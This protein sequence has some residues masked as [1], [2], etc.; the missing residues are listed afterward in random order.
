GWRDMVLIDKGPTPN[1]G[2]STGH[3]SNFIF[4][5][6]YS[7]MMAELTRDSAEQYKALGVHIESGGI[8]VARTQARLDEQARRASAARSCGIPAERLSP[9]GVAERVPYLD[10]SVIK[11][12]LY[13]PTVGVVD[14]LRAGTLMREQA[15]ELG[16]LSVRAGTEV[17]G[18]D[19]ARGRVR[20]VQT[21]EGEIETEL[22]VICCGV[23]SPRLARMAGARIPLTPIVHQM[24]SVGPVPLF[25][26]TTGEIAYPVVRDVDTG[27][28]ERQH[29]ADL[30]IGSYAHRPITVEPDDIPSIEHSVLSPTELPFTKEDFDPQLQDALELMPELLGD[31][32]IG[33]RY[34][35]NGLI[36]MTPDGHPVLGE[37]PEVRGLWTA[38]ASWIKEGPGIGRAVAERMSGSAPEIDVR[39]ADVSRFYEHQ[40]TRRVVRGRARESFNKM[41]G[42]VHPA[43]QWQDGRP[44]RTSPFYEQTRALGAVFHETAGFERP[45]WYASNERLLDRYGDK[46]MPRSAE[47]D[48]RWWSPVINA[49]HLAM[50][51]GCAVVDLGAFAVLDIAGPRATAALQHLTVVDLDV[52]V[53]RVVYTSLLDERGG[54]VSD[55]TAMRL[56]ADRWW[57]VTGASSGMA[58]KKWILD[59]LPDDGS[60]HLVDMTQAIATLGVWGPNARRLLQQIC[61]DDL[62]PA[63]FPFGTCRHIEIGGTIVLA[64]RIS[65]VGELGWE[66]HIGTDEGAHLWGAIEEI[67][68]EHGLVPV[69]I[70][71]Y[72][73]TGRLEKGY[74]AYG[75]ELTADYDLVEAGLAR[76]KV[77]G[78]DFIG[79]SAYLEQRARPPAAV[80]ST[81]VV[82]DHTSSSGELRY[83]LGGEPVLTPS[84]E[85]IVDERG[86]LSSVTS[87]GS[88]PS[89]GRH[90]LMAYLPSDLAVTGTHLA[91][92]Y[93]AEQYPVSVAVAGSTPLFDPG[94]ERVR[95]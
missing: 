50:R 16:A 61:E 89:L 56:G 64:S 46:V 93:F 47:W 19:V 29:G 58:D 84:G 67:G 2:G 7:R 36:S 71:V 74:R 85:P 88:A 94:N 31:E 24:I 18:I 5:I 39:G 1:P 66:L 79:K 86:R 76:A 42:I 10:T 57:L 14:S 62:S 53:G 54:F 51:D 95:S 70:G 82:E 69:G 21:A 49:E 17:R 28:Y 25:A 60:A 37:L 22:C 15:V 72:A 30:E 11:G 77:K 87:A 91:V 27:M 6:E 12:G 8:E 68:G 34:A 52:P 81:L 23:W 75:A 90:L 65:Y 3:A 80:L 63:A 48:A 41:Y 9:A 26:T 40:R 45:E 20:A 32:R 35:I 38:A 33:I 55:L 13:F 92:E 73:T 4:P 59:H 83:M 44:A 78:H 43:E